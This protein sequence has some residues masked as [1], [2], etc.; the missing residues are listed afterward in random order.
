MTH[1]NPQAVEPVFYTADEVCQV[2]GIGKTL[3][4]RLIEEGTIR[5]GKLGGKAVFRRTDIDAVIAK[6]FAEDAA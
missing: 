5:K 1:P 3:L 6:A 2:L 4:Y